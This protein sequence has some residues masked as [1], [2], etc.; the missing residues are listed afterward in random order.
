MKVKTMMNQ[1]KIKISDTISPAMGFEITSNAFGFD[2]RD[3]GKIMGMASYGKEDLSLLPIYKNGKIN[4][5]LFIKTEELNLDCKSF[6]FQDKANFAFA[7]Q[8]ETQKNMKKYIHDVI[9]ITK[10]KNICLSGG[11]FLNCVA[12]YDYLDGFPEDVNLYIEP[13]SL[14]A[15]TSI[16]AAKFIWHL[17]TEDSTIR[18]QNTIYYGPE[19]D[20]SVKDKLNKNESLSK[21]NYEDVISLILKKNPVALYQGRSEAGPRALGNRSILMIQEIKMEKML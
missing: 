4:N 11:F 1:K 6:E 18:K 16:G 15:G 10:C 7:L 12:N 19:P 13:N 20:Y 2:W 8:K 3:A 14:D 5:E 21:V 9:D 17:K